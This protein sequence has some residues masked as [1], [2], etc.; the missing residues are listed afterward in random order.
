MEVDLSLAE[1]TVFM[2][3]GDHVIDGTDR[4]HRDC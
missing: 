1:A 2:C 3:G 4:L